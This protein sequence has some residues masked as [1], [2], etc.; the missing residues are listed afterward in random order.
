MARPMA[1]LVSHR[2]E[3]KCLDI[4]QASYVLNSTGAVT[5][6]N[7]I[8]AGTSFFNRVGRKI[9][10]KSLHLKLFVNPLRTAA[11]QDYVRVMVVYDAQTNGAAPAISDILQDTDQ[12]GTNATN[13]YC[14]P[15]LNNRDRFRV[16]C[17]YKIVI[18]SVT[19]TAGVITNLGPVDPVAPAFD[20]ERFIKLKGLITQYKAD[21]APAVIGDIATGGLFLVTYGGNTAGTEGWQATGTLRLRYNDK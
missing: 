8:R 20:I 3:V 17:D 7:F 2:P 4:P 12:A 18:P 19:S 1:M 9:E 14:G 10:M 5:G 15:N 11:F 16:L 21:S 13:Q 6:L